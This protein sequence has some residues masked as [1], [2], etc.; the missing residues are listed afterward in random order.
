M[1]LAQL[2][3]VLM[4]FGPSAFHCL[5]C[6]G[7]LRCRFGLALHSFRESHAVCFTHSEVWYGYSHTNLSPLSDTLVRNGVA[8][9]IALALCER[10]KFGLNIRGLLNPDLR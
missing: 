5:I 3:F 1:R 10:Y 6:C 8:L 4:M 2:S 7:Y 9:D